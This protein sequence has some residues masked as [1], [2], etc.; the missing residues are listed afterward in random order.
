MQ[1]IRKI[2]IVMI[3]AIV[4]VCLFSSSSFAGGKKWKKH[5][6]QTHYETKAAKHEAHQDWR[7]EIRHSPGHHSDCKLPPGLAKKG[8]LPPGW[9]KKCSHQK[10]K[11]HAKNHDRYPDHDHKRSSGDKEKPAIN[12][13]I[14]IWG[15]VHI[16]FP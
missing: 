5:K 1:P 4:F 2:G 14:D 7:D 11:H 9:A 10:S 8:K 16:P 6:I 12:G 3:P 15:N 13:G